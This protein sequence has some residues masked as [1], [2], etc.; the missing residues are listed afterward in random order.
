MALVLGGDGEVYE[1]HRF[2]EFM[3]VLLVVGKEQRATSTLE[4]Q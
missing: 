4:K 3:S 2:N 1:V